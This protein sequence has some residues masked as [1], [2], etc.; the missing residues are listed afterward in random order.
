MFPCLSLLLVAI[1]RKIDEVNAVMSGT[2]YKVGHVQIYKRHRNTLNLIIIP[3]ALV[4][5]LVLLGITL[6]LRRLRSFSLSIYYLLLCLQ[7]F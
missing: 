7:I 2:V 6:F 3:I 5:I 4:F 1:E